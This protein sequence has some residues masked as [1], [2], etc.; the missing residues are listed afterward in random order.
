MKHTITIREARE[1]DAGVLTEFN[2]AMARETETLELEYDMVLS[3]VRNL[4]RRPEY[5]FYLIAEQDCSIVGMVMIT[6][7]WSDWRDGLYWW[8]QSLY[9]VPEFRRQG[10]FRRF[11]GHIEERAAESGNVAGI[12]LYVERDNHVAQRAYESVGIDRTPYQVY[13]KLSPV[14]RE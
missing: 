5:G 6:F 12:R 10:I 13:E 8:I 9:V 4:L 14:S 2:R 7:E 3:G 1:Q 11:F